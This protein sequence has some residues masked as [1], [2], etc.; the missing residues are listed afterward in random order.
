M[1]K[2]NEIHRPS[3]STIISSTILKPF[4]GYG[5]FQGT[6]L[7]GPHLK[8]RLL[9]YAVIFDKSP[10]QIRYYTYKSLRPWIIKWHI[11]LNF[12]KKEITR[13]KCQN[14]CAICIEPLAEIGTSSDNILECGHRFH[15]HCIQASIDSKQKKCPL[16]RQLII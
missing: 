13:L 9:K 6:I 4:K 2:K 14:M 12:K 5:S 7:N 10:N 8:G 16:C 1:V 11:D 15:I 3:G